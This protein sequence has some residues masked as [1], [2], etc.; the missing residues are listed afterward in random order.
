MITIDAHSDYGVQYLRE[1]LKDNPN[2][3]IEQ[4]YPNLIKGGVNV[5]V[6]IIGGDFTLPGFV[7]NNFDNTLLVIEKINKLV[8]NNSDKLFLIKSSDDFKNISE[9]K[10]G[11]ILGIEG[12]SV[13]D[14]ELNNFETLYELGLRSVILTHNEDNIFADG[15]NVEDSKGLTEEGKTFLKVL[16]KK[17]VIVDLVHLSEK[18]FWDAIE[19]IEKPPIISHSNVKKL[20][21]IKRNLTDEQIKAI[22]ERGGV[23]GLNFVAIFVDKDFSKTTI[24]RLIDHIDYI[25]NLVGI[26]HIGIGPDFADYFIEDVVKSLSNRN[27]TDDYAKYTPGLEDVTKMNNLIDGLVK[28]NFSDDDIDK[29]MGENFLSV[30]KKII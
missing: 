25:T 5:E 3:F 14:K 30:Y 26:K 16:N 15:C 20:S 21:N 27:I 28:R 11:V 6:L 12:A 29:I 23:I 2:A 13:V 9:K 17:N 4:H 8:E 24:D 7:F 10:I 1:I 22:A 19:V 18:S